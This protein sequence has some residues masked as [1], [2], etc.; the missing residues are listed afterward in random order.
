MKLFEDLPST[1]T[2][3]NAENLN[4]IKDKLVVVSSTEPTGDNREKVWTQKGKNLY[5]PQNAYVT[6][7]LSQ[8]IGLIYRDIK[9]GQP[10]TFSATNYSWVSV[11]TYN[12]ANELIRE[13]GNTELTKEV[14]I[15]IQDT[16]VYV[17]LLYEDL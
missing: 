13:V 16:E 11:K 5:N 2:P 9:V 12:S 3:I 1:N 7:N 17:E 14:T 4:Q 10:Y 15:T 8:N 6:G